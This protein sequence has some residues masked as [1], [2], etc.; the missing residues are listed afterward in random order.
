MEGDPFQRLSFGS[1][2]NVR[3]SRNG[4]AE[5]CVDM[6]QSGNT[7]RGMNLRAFGVPCGVGVGLYPSVEDLP[8]CFEAGKEILGYEDVDALF[9]AGVQSLPA[10]SDRVNAVAEGGARVLAEHTFK[11]RAER[12]LADLENLRCVSDEIYLDLPNA[13]YSRCRFW[14]DLRL[15]CS[16]ELVRIPTATP[17]NPTL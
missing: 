13:S 12:K 17:K 14:L 2:R 16:P 9:F 6:L 5:L 11:H 4:I 1:V 7:D 10:N 15:R 3:T 8:K